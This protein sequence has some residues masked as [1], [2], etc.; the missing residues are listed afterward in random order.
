MYDVKLQSFGII[1]IKDVVQDGRRHIVIPWKFC[2]LVYLSS[3]LF[4]NTPFQIV[5]CPV[6]AYRLP[7]DNFG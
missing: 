6:N 4:C 2:K 3:I 1:S 7:L 5:C